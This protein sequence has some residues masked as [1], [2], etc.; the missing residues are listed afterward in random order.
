MVR[1]AHQPLVEATCLTVCLVGA[2]PS[3]SSI[4]YEKKLII[5]GIHPIIPK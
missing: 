2:Y 3:T 4:M 5:R 1:Q